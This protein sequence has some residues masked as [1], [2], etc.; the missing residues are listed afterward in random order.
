V[1]GAHNEAIMISD[2]V[3]GFFKSASLQRFPDASLLSAAGDA[4]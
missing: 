3:S 1:P 2:D 4:S